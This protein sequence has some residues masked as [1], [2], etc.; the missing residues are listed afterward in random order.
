MRKIQYLRGKCIGC[1]ACVIK[2]PHIWEMSFIDGKVDLLDS[3]DKNS[4]YTR[5]LWDDEVSIMNDVV[6]VCPVK[7]IKIV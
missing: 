4:I 2:A 6:A 5:M 3:E 7:A 1:G